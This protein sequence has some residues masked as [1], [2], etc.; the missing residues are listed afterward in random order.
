ME[1]EKW[2]FSQAKTYI[3]SVNIGNPIGLK[4]NET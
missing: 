1:V 3:I 4:N 2:I